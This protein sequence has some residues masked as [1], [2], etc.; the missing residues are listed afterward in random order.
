MKFT[1]Y[2]PPVINTRVLKYSQEIHFCIRKFKKY[3]AAND[4]IVSHKISDMFAQSCSTK[5]FSV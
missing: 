4:P 1:R 2:H 5:V 3:T